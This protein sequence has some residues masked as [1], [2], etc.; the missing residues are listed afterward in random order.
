MDTSYIDVFTLAEH[1]QSFEGGTRI[2]LAKTVFAELRITILPTAQLNAITDQRAM[3][4]M[5]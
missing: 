5:I 4:V 2:E 3:Q 1:F